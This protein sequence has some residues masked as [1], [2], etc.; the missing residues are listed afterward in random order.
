MERLD[1]RARQRR[2]PNR[3]AALLELAPAADDSLRA[4]A[5]HGVRADPLANQPKP[6][7]EVLEVRGA[8]EHDGQVRRRAAESESRAS[9][10]LGERVD[11]GVFGREAAGDPRGHDCIVAVRDSGP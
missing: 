4:T 8:A 11:S 1:A 3:H 2:G 5:D 6:L 7:V 10:R 9:G